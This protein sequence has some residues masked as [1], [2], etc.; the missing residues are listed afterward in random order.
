MGLD[1]EKGKKFLSLAVRPDILWCPLTYTVRT[2][3][4]GL[5]THNSPPFC[6]EVKNDGAIPP[7]LHTSSWHGAKLIKHMNVEAHTR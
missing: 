7:L 4:P 5:E 1:F 2:W 3:R 6:V